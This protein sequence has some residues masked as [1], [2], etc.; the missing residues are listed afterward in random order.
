[1][2]GEFSAQMASNAETIFIWWRHHG[3]RNDGVIYISYNVHLELKTF[4]YI[5]DSH[6]KIYHEEKN[7]FVIISIIS[8]HCVFFLMNWF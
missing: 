8:K 3:V 2:T 4:R 1:M 7:P 6:M 5:L